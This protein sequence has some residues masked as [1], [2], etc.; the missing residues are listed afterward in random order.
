MAWAKNYLGTRR[1]PQKPKAVAVET[2]PSPSAKRIRPKAG[3]L[4]IGRT[5]AQ[6]RAATK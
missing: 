4:P 5:R 6:W 1:P 3:W 2:K